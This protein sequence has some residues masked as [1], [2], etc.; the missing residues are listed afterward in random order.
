MSWI[1]VHRVV[2]GVLAY[3]LFSLVTTAAEQIDDEV[4][5]TSICELLSDP[6]KYDHALVKITGIMSHGF[7]DFTFADEACPKESIWLEYGGLRGSGTIF[8]GNP[9]SA[10]K[11]A[12]KLEVEGIQTSLIEDKK[13]EALDRKV[14]L[15]RAIQT[16]ATLIGRYYAGELVNGQFG[17]FQV[18]YGHLGMF[19]LLIIQ[20]VGTAK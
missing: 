18:G 19:S 20:Q 6:P 11:R 12:H 15:K 7:E 8:A 4:T 1:F 13:F 14:R 5:S 16:D 9:S 17:S 10:R 3:F 2:I